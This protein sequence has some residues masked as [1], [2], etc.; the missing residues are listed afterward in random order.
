MPLIKQTRNMR[1]TIYE[2]RE[3]VQMSMEMIG[4]YITAQRPI[5]YVNYS[6]LIEFIDPRNGLL[7][8]MFSADCINNR[9]KLAIE[10]KA[11][12]E[13]HNIML[14]QCVNRR[15]LASYNAFIQCLLQTKQLQ[16]VSLLEPSLVGDVRPLSKDQQSRLQ[17]NYS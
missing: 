14:L 11:T 7:D 15:S 13:K 9:Q 8:K 10:G 1:L 12:N 2:A 3:S 5:Q 17:K 6:K 16:V 4:L